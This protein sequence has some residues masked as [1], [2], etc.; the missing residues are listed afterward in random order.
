MAAFATTRNG[1]TGATTCA[2]RASVDL[3]GEAEPFERRRQLRE[4]V[5][6]G[7]RAERL[8]RSPRIA[9]THQDERHGGSVRDGSVV[10]AVADHRG[11]PGAAAEL[12]DQAEQMAGVGLSHG[13]PV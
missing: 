5:E 8:L 13:I 11:L 1:V 9:V 4:T 10:F 3:R 12:A 2:R 7:V 6:N